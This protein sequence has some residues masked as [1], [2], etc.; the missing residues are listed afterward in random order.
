ML[1]GSGWVGDRYGR[2][3]VLYA[4]CAVSLVGALVYFPLVDTKVWPLILLASLLTVGPIHA[5]GGARAPLFA[6]S[7]PTEV[8]YTGQATVSTF[9][10]LLGG[11]LAPFIATALLAWTDST[12]SIAGFAVVALV[13]QLIALTFVRETAWVDIEAPYDSPGRPGGGEQAVDR[14]ATDRGV[15]HLSGVGEPEGGPGPAHP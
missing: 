5:G 9:G 12:W 10:N 13:G 8:R 4:V 1:L 2:K 11:S 7:F 6:E 3:P 15:E 14:Q